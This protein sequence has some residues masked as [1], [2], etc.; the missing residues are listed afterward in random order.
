M[1]LDTF[2]MI[3]FTDIKVGVKTQ[4]EALDRMRE[5]GFNVN[6]NNRVVH[7]RMMKSRNILK[8]IQLNE[9]SSLTGSMELL[10]KVNDP[11][12]EVALG[13]TV[14]VP[15]WEITLINS[16]PKSKQRL[17]VILSG[18]SVGPAM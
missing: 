3:C 7:N 6:P 4:A 15:R 18:L 17:S 10:K 9:T 8:N 14:K 1:K 12:T 5:L 2:Y 16:L 13:N 11:D